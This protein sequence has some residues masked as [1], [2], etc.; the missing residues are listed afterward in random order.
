MW[1]KL[2]GKQNN[3]EG[4]M[5]LVAIYFDF[6]FRGGFTLWTSSKG[7]YHY[8]KINRNLLSLFREF[9]MTKIKFQL[10]FIFLN[11]NESI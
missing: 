8:S 10:V 3:P 2:K 1:L 9:T 4:E 11:V 6:L 7:R 5:G